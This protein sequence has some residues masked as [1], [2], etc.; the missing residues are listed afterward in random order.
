MQNLLLE[1]PAKSLKVKSEKNLKVKSAKILKDQKSI[2]SVGK[3]CKKNL[4]V[5]STKSLMVKFLKNLK[6]KPAKILK[7]KS[8][9]R[10]KKSQLGRICKFGVCW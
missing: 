6:L 9:H 7:V 5:K 8:V 3:I 10:E 4:W 2:N 1:L